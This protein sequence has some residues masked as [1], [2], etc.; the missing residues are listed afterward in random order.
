ML[1]VISVSKNLSV[2]GSIRHIL[3]IPQSQSDMTSESR[4]PP[5]PLLKI[6]VSVHEQEDLGAPAG[7]PP[8]GRGPQHPGGQGSRAS[9]SSSP[10]AP[11]APVSPQR[12]GSD[13]RKIIAQLLDK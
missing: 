13:G 3:L 1:K 2:S 7:E 4:P 5:P 8:G 9:P 12:D 6:P 10:R 11:S